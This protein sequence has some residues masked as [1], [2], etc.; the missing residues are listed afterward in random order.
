[1]S[2]YFFIETS[3]PFESRDC[4]NLA[5]TAL[6]LQSRGNQV[7]VMLIQNGVLA[8][9]QQARGSHTPGLLKAGI[10]VMVDDFSLRERGISAA[11]LAPG[12]KESSI[13]AIADA[14]LEGT[15]TIWH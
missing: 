3:D 14:L 2:K 13:D 15:K 7:T 6:D 10:T 12:I 4:A 8:A 9:R 1:M 5:Q 11:E